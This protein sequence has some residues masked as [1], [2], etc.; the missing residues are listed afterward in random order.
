[1]SP[2]SSIAFSILSTKLCTQFCLRIAHIGVDYDGTFGKINRRG[3]H[4]SGSCCNTALASMRYVQCVQAGQKIHSPDPSDPL[5]AQQVFVANALLSKADRLET[6][7]LATVELPHVLFDCIDELMERIITKCQKDIPTG[8]K[9]ALLGG[10]QINAEFPRLKCENCLSY[11][12]ENYSLDL[13]CVVLFHFKNLRF[14]GY[15]ITLQLQG[16]TTDPHSLATIGLDTRSVSKGTT[17]FLA[18]GSASYRIVST[19]TT[20]NTKTINKNNTYRLNVDVGKAYDLTD[21]KLTIRV[22]PM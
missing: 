12:Y 22:T 16:I 15:D 20:S 18:F 5:N 17:A 14:Y 13:C 9:I 1:M 6:S 11:L 7:E 4:G 21:I 3:H 8:T 2:Y 10:I 19:S